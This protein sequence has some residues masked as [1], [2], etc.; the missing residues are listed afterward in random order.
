MRL[1]LTRFFTAPDF[2]IDSTRI[3][4][5]ERFQ[6]WT[7]E[8]RQSD[9]VQ[10]LLGGGLSRILVTMGDCGVLLLYRND[11]D[12]VEHLYVRAPL[13]K[14]DARLVNVSGAGDWCV[15]ICT[16]IRTM[17]FFPSVSTPASYARTTSTINPFAKRWCLQQSARA[18]R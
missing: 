15:L 14:D 16:L 6:Q 8:V 1:N 11:N 12:Y 17:P 4:D 9:F 13:N 5:E 2:N 10:R 3:Y 18:V 7:S